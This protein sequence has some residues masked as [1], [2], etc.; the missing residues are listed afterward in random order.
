MY[1]VANHLIVEI[2]PKWWTDQLTDLPP[3]T[4]KT[5]HIYTPPNYNEVVYVVDT[6][7]N[8]ALREE[9][10]Y[11]LYIS[12]SF[13]SDL[14]AV[15]P[16]EEHWFESASPEDFRSQI[17][18]TALCGHGCGLHHALEYDHH[19]QLR[20]ILQ[21]LPVDLEEG[22][23]VVD[24]VYDCHRRDQEDAVGASVKTHVDVRIIQREELSLCRHP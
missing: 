4:P 6:T 24:L 18:A 20:V 23:L 21:G 9:S 14:V 8:I 7:S 12:L 13:F 17:G 11:F 16:L 10:K 22:R 3:R 15:F 2:F 1:F 19:L 5:L